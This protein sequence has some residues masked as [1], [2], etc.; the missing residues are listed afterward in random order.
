MQ[1]PYLADPSYP[2]E[3]ALTEE[4]LLEIQRARQAEQMGSFLDRP[5]YYSAGGNMKDSA[6]V[7]GSSL[8]FPVGDAIGLGADLDMYANDPESRTMLNYGLTAAGLLP[9]IP[10]LASIMRRG[11]AGSADVLMPPDQTGAVGPLAE[12]KGGK[13]AQKYLTDAEN[14]KL[15]KGTADK[16]MAAREQLPA[17]SEMANVARAGEAK[18]GWYEGSSQAISDL[19]QEEAPTFAGLLSATSPQ[20]SVESNLKNATSIWSNWKKAGSPTDRES[21][22]DIMGESVEGSRGRDSVLDA[23]I[24]N[25][26]RSLE[27]PNSV[28]PN[29]LSGPK[30]DSF[31]RNLLGNTD[32]VTNDA[33][34]ARYAGIPQTSF[35]GSINKTDAGK[36]PGYLAMSSRTREA[37]DRLSQ[38]TGDLWTPDNVQETVWSFSKALREA[39][40]AERGDTVNIL[41]KGLLGDEMIA[42]TPDFATLLRDPAYAE[43]LGGSG[44]DVGRMA[45][46]TPASPSDYLRSVYGEGTKTRRDLERA[47]R[48]LR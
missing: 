6:I 12:L 17:A 34:M 30:V 20:T 9:A 11:D 40:N 2:Q 7:A 16:F 45:D 4:E 8:P 22:I 14:A 28:D 10:A 39:Q 23:W 38:Q 18:K 19:F 26:V 31:M 13:S 21:I 15:N 24:N 42:D 43:L 48:R 35:A 36:G 41:R 27:D 37:A 29:M 1:A 47:A 5:D 25:T 3:G 46:P 33:W 32:E 44:Y